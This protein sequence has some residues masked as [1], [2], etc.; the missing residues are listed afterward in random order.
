M[1]ENEE[2]T[3]PDGTLESVT[4]PEELAE[5]G[6]ESGVFADVPGQKG[7][8]RLP[9]ARQLTLVVG[10]LAGVFGIGMIPYLAGH[11]DDWPSVESALPQAGSPKDVGNKKLEDTFQNVTLSAKSALVLD[12]RTGDLLYEKDIVTKRPLASITKL[13]TAL[14]ARE[15]AENGL[16]VPISKEAVSQA[17]EGGLRVGERYSIERLTDLTLLTSSNDGAYALAAA[18]GAVIDPQDGAAAFVKAMNVRANELGLKETYFRNPTGLDITEEE[19]GAYGSAR[20][21]AKLLEYILVN[22]PEILEETTE[23]KTL[24]DDLSGAMHSASNTNPVADAIPSLIGSKTGYTTLAGGNL[25]VVFNAGADRPI[26]VVILGSTHSGRFS[27]VLE[28]IEATQAK[29]KTEE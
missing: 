11:L 26:I 22:Y 28:L 19:A 20:D 13:M 14:V 2:N 5:A 10:V 6:P 25:A 7:T 24:I 27:D 21:V 16:V 15:V 23:R 4:E 18:A 1:N 12:V 17:G 9:V 3:T 8:P 29:L